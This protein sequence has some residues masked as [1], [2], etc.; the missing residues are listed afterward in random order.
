[1]TEA[2][3]KLRLYREKR[4]F[5]KTAE[6]P[7]G[8]A[9]D[10]AKNLVF[11][12][13][14]HAA[15]R[16]HWDFRLEVDG[17]L[18]SWPLP[19]GPSL[20]PRE[21]R[22]AVMVED[23]PYEYRNFEG[24]I[25]QGE[26]GGGQVIIWDEGTY[27][28]DEGGR[29]SWND[30]QEGNRRMLEGLKKGKLSFTLRGHKLKGSF[31]LVKTRYSKDSWLLIK[32]Q[33]EYA[34]SRDVLEQDRSVR[35]GLTIQDL[36]EGRLPSGSGRAQPHPAAKGCPFPDARRE[37]PM[38]AT[39][40][41]RAFDR[42]GWLWEPKLDGIRILA[43]IRDGQVELRSRRGLDCTKQYPALAAD[44][45]RQAH[46][47]LVLD[48]EVCALDEK[49]VPRFQLLQPRINLTRA[50]DIARME[51]EVPVVYFVFDVLYAQGWDLRPVPLKER[52]ALLAGYL[53]QGDRVKLV[54]FVEGDGAAMEEAAAAAGFEGVVGKR[55]DSRYEPGVRSRSW[56]KVK[57][58]TRQEF[59]VGGYTPG[60]GARARTFGALA[61][62]Y[63]DDQGRLIHAGNVGSGFK[64]ADLAR[65]HAR[66]KGLETTESPFANRVEGKVVWLRPELVAE[67][68][69]AE[70]TADTHLRAPVFLGLRDDIDPRQVRKEAPV[71]QE[72]ALTPSMPEAPATRPD[73]SVLAAEVARLLEQIDSAPK[74]KEL[75][76]EVEG[77]RIKLTNLD[78]EFWPAYRL[79]DPL[80]AQKAEERRPLTKGDMVR[81]YAT[82]AQWMLPHLKDR[83]LTLTR[84]PNGIASHFYQKHYS[85]PIPS[86]VETT[87][88][89]SEDNQGDGV[90]LMCNNLPTLIW[91]AQIA[92]LEIH[93][94]LSRVDPRP[95]A[96][97][98]PVSAAGSREAARRS[99]LN[100][101]DYM[102]FDLDPYIYSGHE[103][104]GA[105]PEFNR[106]AWEKTVSIALD[107]KDLL[108]QLKLSSFV[109]TTG[110]TGLHVYVPVLREYSYDDVR[111][112]CRL[113]GLQLRSQRPDDVSLD[114]DTRKR[115]GKVF[116]DY[117]QN[118]FG[119]QL[120]SQY[121]LR[122]TPWA[123]VST[124]VLWSELPTVDP[125]ALDMSTV[126]QRLQESGDPWAAIL[127]HKNDLSLLA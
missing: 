122:P 7:P 20:D 16:M 14:Q 107:L 38:L 9:D 120:V 44:L 75:I 99:V 18:K 42:P 93:A 84:Y 121:S 79:A 90:Y 124:P 108:D 96:L 17:V 68:K 40:I 57:A 109:K 52:K 82:V 28:P 51:A 100:Y 23:H 65:I 62:G 118:T 54:A 25:P 53:E 123:G 30:K 76:V 64:D 43:Y 58:V 5:T 31:T 3:E 102:V 95:D 89:W 35:S 86:F 85:Q 26:Y 2:S 6:P 114:W 27:T 63:Y 61:L 19:K 112:F 106:K 13:Q 48:G 11:V 97:G 36:K 33:D 72:V 46:Q 22:M 78:K 119:K 88:I 110:K 56:V 94:W 77:E 1:M 83:P 126:P 74:R 29:T 117:N 34:T 103:K 101:P 105:E 12:V 67:V 71:P 73:R 50:T 41:E 24:V 70:W 55:A 98:H 81:Y 59:V 37:R 104:K 111:E 116:Y 21:K 92:D 66:L 69:F 10:E 39:L 49:G 113:I 4:D 60:E 91:L 32:H 15:R 125:L 80:A 45:A 47:P 87:R 115:T 8:G 127:D